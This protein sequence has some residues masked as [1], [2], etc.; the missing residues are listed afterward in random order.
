M[1]KKT[2]TADGVCPLPLTGCRQC[3]LRQEFPPHQPGFMPEI[4]V[5]ILFGK[6][7]IVGLNEYFVLKERR[8]GVLCRIKFIEISLTGKVIFTVDRAFF[9]KNESAGGKVRQFFADFALAGRWIKNK[10]DILFAGNP[11][12]K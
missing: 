8:N 1:A 2:G 7:D 11:C 4:H 10:P 9:R 5:L 3:R 12:H 6:M